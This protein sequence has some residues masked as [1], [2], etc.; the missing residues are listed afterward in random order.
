MSDNYEE[1]KSGLKNLRHMERLSQQRM[2][3]T[4]P[5]VVFEQCIARALVDGLIVPLYAMKCPRCGE[6]VTTFNGTPDGAHAEFDESQM[7]ICDTPLCDHE[8]DY[9]PPVVQTVYF[10]DPS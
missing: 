9:D 6:F 1:F 7:E 3:S 8:F 2:R 5:G 4:L 10:N